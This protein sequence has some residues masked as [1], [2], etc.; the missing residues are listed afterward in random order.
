MSVY[1]QK[2]KFIG[3]NIKIHILQNFYVC[4]K[5]QYI[6]YPAHYSRDIL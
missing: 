4:H 6:E 3:K 2:L 1:A 5:M